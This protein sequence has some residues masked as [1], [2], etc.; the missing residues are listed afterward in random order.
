[1]SWNICKFNPLHKVKLFKEPPPKERI[2]ILEEEKKLLDES[3]K[4]LRPILI[5]ALNTGM[6]YREILD[7]TWNDVN[8]EPGN[9]YV[10]KSKSGKG[11]NIPINETLRETISELQSEKSVSK[12]VSTDLTMNKK[13]SK[14]RESRQMTDWIQDPVGESPWGFKSPL[15]HQ[16]INNR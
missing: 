10:R 2:L 15:R 4:H 7:L 16:N 3:P 13:S 8:L 6:R 5:T 9:I 1:M 14:Y 11:R 12:F